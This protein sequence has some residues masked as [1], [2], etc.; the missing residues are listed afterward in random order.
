MYKF[1]AATLLLTACAPLDDVSYDRHGDSRNDATPMYR[2]ETERGAL[3][4]GNDQDYFIAPEAGPSGFVSWRVTASEE[5]LVFTFWVE[6]ESGAVNYFGTQSVF[7]GESSSDYAN[8]GDNVVNTGI[9]VWSQY[10]DPG[11]EYTVRLQQV[12]GP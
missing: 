3:Q 5:P 9:V 11:A 10:G 7:P 12:M 4:T 8:L 1:L 2:G 6:T